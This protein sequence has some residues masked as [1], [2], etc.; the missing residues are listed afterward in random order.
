MKRSRENFTIN[1]L[2][3]EEA[4][5]LWMGFMIYGNRELINL[6]EKGL[7]IKNKELFP[8]NLLHFAC[9]MNYMENIKFLVA[10][11]FDVNLKD[12]KNDDGVTP[13]FSFV[14]T[15]NF[16]GIKLLESFGALLT[17]SDMNGNNLLHYLS[18]ELEVLKISDKWTEH[19]EK[20]FEIVRYLVDKGVNP[21]AL[22][23]E[24]QR[25]LDLFSDGFGNSRNKFQRAIEEGL[26][27]R[28]ALGNKLFR[29]LLKESIVD[30]EFY[31]Y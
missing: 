12:Y 29:I 2:T 24:N 7:D 3:K 30:I 6:V 27:K 10:H 15:L 11:G 18:R 20:L 16:E 21:E 31:Y 8:D 26:V 28:R 4:E 25:V 14:Y 13:V 5:N 23:K 17:I 1:N 19:Q 22:N 9:C